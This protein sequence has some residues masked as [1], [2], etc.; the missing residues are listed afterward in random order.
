MKTLI[1]LAAL[2]V[3]QHSYARGF[4]CHAICVSTQ[5]Q[6]LS[7]VSFGE[8]KNEGSIT[9]FTKKTLFEKL[10]SKCTKLEAQYNFDEAGILV[11]SLIASEYR[12]DEVSQ[13]YTH[14]NQF[15]I[16]VGVKV[17]DP[18]RN[19]VYV[20]GYDF[21]RIQDWTRTPYYPISSSTHVKYYDIR[22]WQ[23]TADFSCSET[24]DIADTEVPEYDGEFPILGD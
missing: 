16:E 22:Y 19:S 11:D 20:S 13:R 12:Y 4:R 15:N 14:E 24:N 23:S 8:V 1:I 3:A 17:T 2:V 6:P 18:N 5:V 10:V 21:R 9:Y 7:V